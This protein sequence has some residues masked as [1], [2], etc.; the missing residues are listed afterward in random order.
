MVISRYNQDQLLCTSNACGSMFI[1]VCHYITNGRN[2]FSKFQFYLANRDTKEISIKR[3][4]LCCDSLSSMNTW[5]FE[6]P[7]LDF[8][9]RLSF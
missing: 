5:Y 9:M 2:I 3:E 1:G 4:E 8:N 7:L 6:I